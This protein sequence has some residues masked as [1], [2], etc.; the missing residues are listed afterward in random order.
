VRQ[1]LPT[2]MPE[3][4]SR[5]SQS[6]RLN[7]RRVKSSMWS[8]CDYATPR[9]ESPNCRAR[10]AINN[11]AAWCALDTPGQRASR[12]S[13]WP[14]C[15][16]PPPRC[17]EASCQSPNLALKNSWHR[18]FHFLVLQWPELFNVHQCHN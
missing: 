8:Q 14:F 12:P 11:S 16:V 3:W 10:G 6:T 7:Q 4:T 1:P 13:S 17:R 18:C 15:P 5:R 9:H 2:A